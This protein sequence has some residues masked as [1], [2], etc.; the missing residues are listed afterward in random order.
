MYQLNIKDLA[1][2]DQITILRM[3]DY[4]NSNNYKPYTDCK[5]MTKKQFQDD[6]LEEII[7]DTG[8]TSL[9]EAFELFMAG[10]GDGD[11]NY[12]VLALRDGQ[13]YP[14]VH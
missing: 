10:S 4:C 7:A 6:V 14:V 13:I 8:V 5:M 12:C 3:D 1:E 11:D 9:V 2:T